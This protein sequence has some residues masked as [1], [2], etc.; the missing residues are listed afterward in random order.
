MRGH[1]D[2]VVGIWPLV[3]G[4]EVDQ[5]HAVADHR[6]GVGRTAVLMLFRDQRNFL[7]DG[8]SSWHLLAPLAEGAERGEALA[9]VIG[10]ATS[11]SLGIG[12][13]LA[14]GAALQVEFGHA[15][16]GRAD[17]DRGV[18]IERQ[19]LLTLL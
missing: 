16:D 11:R 14:I 6:D 10:F 8:A 13:D 1:R 12:L 5:A 3:A 4:L 18:R 17:V 7:G 15:V 19:T 9:Q 2:D